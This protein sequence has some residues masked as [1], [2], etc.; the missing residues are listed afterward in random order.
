M[1]SVRGWG[2]ANLP[3]VAYGW[4][5][6]VYLPYTLVELLVWCGAHLYGLSVPKN[7]VYLCVC[8]C[9]GHGG[10]WLEG[11]FFKS[12]SLQFHLLH[13]EE[14][15]SGWYRKQGGGSGREISRVKSHLLRAY[16]GIPSNLHTLMGVDF[17]CHYR[18]KKQAR[19]A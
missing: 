8:A 6:C 16:V 7:C 13:G 15:H 18:R 12:I 17:T 9:A 1:L 11:L 3:M 14:R 19:E 2:E 4:V 10:G 5:Q